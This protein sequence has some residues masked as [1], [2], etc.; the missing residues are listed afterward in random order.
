MLTVLLCGTA[1]ALAWKGW[2]FYRLGLEE[3]PDHPDFRTLRPSGTLGNGY[4]YAGAL[5]VFMNL[6]YLVR[7]RF[8]SARLGSMRVWL[9]LHVFTG[10]LAAVF[11]SFHSAF[12]LRTPIA[13]WTSVSLLIVVATGLLGRFLYALSPA[14]EAKKL[15]AAIAALDGA[16]PGIGRE[17]D[18]A[19]AGLPAPQVRANASLL[20]AIL[21]IPRWRRVSRQRRETLTLLLAQRDLGRATRALP[22]AVLKGASADARASGASALLRTWRGLH[23][24]FAI[25]MLLAVGLH[26]GIAWYYGYRWIFS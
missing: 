7:R 6:S 24:F 25:L 3:R 10:L 17:I 19:L 26:I 1:A 18:V 14:G 5:L 20:G 23:R 4:G 15:G 11:V 13:T 21:A 16:E 12:Q 2:T 22:R 9:D 8:S